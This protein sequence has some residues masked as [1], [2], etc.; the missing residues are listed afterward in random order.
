MKTTFEV[1]LAL[2]PFVALFAGFLLFRLNGLV[3]SFYAWLCE[4]A[5]F[6]FYYDMPVIRSVEASLWSN[7][8]MWSAFLVI[9]AGQIFGQAYRATGLLSVL[10]EAVESIMPAGDRKGRAIAM[11][12]VVGGFIGAFNGFATYPVT[13][14]GL[15]ELGFDGVQAITAYLCFFSWQ[16]SFVSLFISAN[17]ANAAT[18][19]PIASLAPYIGILN[20]PLCFL[21]CLGFFKLL[22]FRLGD[23][24]SQVLMLLS[25]TA[26]VIAITVFCILWPELYILTLIG[27]AGL[28]LLFLTLYGR[29]AGRLGING[30]AKASDRATAPAK[31]NMGP[32]MQAFAPLLIGIACVLVAHLPVVEHWLEGAAFKVALWGYSPTKVSFFTSAGFF[33]L[34]TAASCYVFS[35]QSANPLRDFV[36]ASRRASSSLA[37]FFVGSAMVYLMVDSGQVKLLGDVLSGGGRVVYAAFNPV[38]AYFAGMAFGQGLPA[39]FMLSKLQMTV[40]PSLAIGLPLLVAIVTVETVGPNNPLKPTIIRLGASLVG[41]E[42]KDPLIFRLL[43]PWQLLGL[44]VTAV[45]AFVL[46][47]M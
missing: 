33:V 40:G 28:S 26:N 27:G 34:I 46:A 6:L 36:L 29:Y 10:C 20:I 21:T 22:G 17:I 31:R 4:M 39:T 9:Y 18:Q 5:V 13:I 44:A 16:E 38:L 37:T 32:A 7:I 35:V 42:G 24:D 11:V 12:A 8:A 23:R 43:L 3:A 25:G 14:P 47:L 30:L 45:I 41:V 19:I 15:V 1:A 2:V